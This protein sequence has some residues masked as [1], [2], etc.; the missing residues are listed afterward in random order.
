[1]LSTEILSINMLKPLVLLI[2][3][4]F[5][6]TLGNY[7]THWGKLSLALV[8]IDEVAMRDAHFVNLGKLQQGL[9]PVSFYGMY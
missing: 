6:K 1:M 8:V 7:I 4:N 9:V 3:G 5:G 2:E